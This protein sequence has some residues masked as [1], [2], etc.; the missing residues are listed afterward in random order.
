MTAEW[1][2]F[3]ILHRAEPVRALGFWGRPVAFMMKNGKLCGP[4]QGVGLAAK[5][6]GLKGSDHGL[7]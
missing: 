3:R 7:P 4:H 2:Y 6:R 5:A 1:T